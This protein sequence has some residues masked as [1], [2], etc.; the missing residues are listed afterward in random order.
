VDSNF[1]CPPEKEI[2]VEALEKQDTFAKISTGLSWILVPICKS[3]CELLR[4]GMFANQIR[5]APKKFRISFLLIFPALNSSL[6]PR[7]KLARSISLG[8]GVESTSLGSLPPLLNTSG[9]IETLA[10]GQVFL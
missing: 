6:V 9:K 2:H 10:P 4:C 7:S 8:H 3:N 5:K 1:G